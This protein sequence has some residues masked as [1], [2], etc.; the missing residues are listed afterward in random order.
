M[1]KRKLDSTV[2]E[3][4]MDQQICKPK[5]TVHILLKIWRHTLSG[6]GSYC[7]LIGWLAGYLQVDEIQVRFEILKA[8]Y[9]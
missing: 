2:D 9:T 3:S 6:T 4:S 8:F 7:R 1:D 5:V